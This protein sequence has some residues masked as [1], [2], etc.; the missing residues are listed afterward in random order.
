MFNA[1]YLASLY[2]PS[3]LLSGSFLDSQ[4]HDRSLATTMN[5]DLTKTQFTVVSL[6][7]AGYTK[8]EIIAELTCSS[9]SL[10][11]WLRQIKQKHGF[12]TLRQIV[13]FYRI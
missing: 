11:N 10:D 6:L 3:A 2:S 1:D 9:K 5:H 13:N 7:V 8:S 12:T 4:E